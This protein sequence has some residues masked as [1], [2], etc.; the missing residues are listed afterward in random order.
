MCTQLGNMCTQLGNIRTQVGNKTFLTNY[1]LFAVIHYTATVG[2]GDETRATLNGDKKY[3]FQTGDKLVILGENISGDL[4]L[5]TGAGT[6]SATFSGDL[7]YNG[8]GTPAAG[9]RDG[10]SLFDDG[11]LGYYWLS[12]YDTESYSLLLDFNSSNAGTYYGLYDFGQR[13][14]GYSVR[15][16]Q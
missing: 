3:E 5:T 14:L 4:T 16:A 2:E 9:L 10:T 12:T 13:C 7:T 11:S 1:F 15:P 8:S 6:A